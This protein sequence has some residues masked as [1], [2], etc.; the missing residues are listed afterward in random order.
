MWNSHTTYHPRIGYTEMPSIRR[1]VQSESG[2]YLVRT[3][4]AGFRSDCEFVKERSPGKARA[5]L[6]GDSQT[7]G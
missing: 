4:A 3:N 6:F 1:R 7:A 5:I 2:G